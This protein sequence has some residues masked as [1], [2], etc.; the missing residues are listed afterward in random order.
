MDRNMTRNVVY[1]GAIGLLALMV[2]MLGIFLTAFTPKLPLMYKIA[3]GYKGW[4]VVRYQDPSCAP[5]RREN[6]FFVISIPSSGIG[7]TSDV[8][9]PGWRIE[10]YEYV[11]GAKAIRRLPQSPWGGNGEIWAGFAMPDKHSESFFVGSEQ[12]LQRSWASRPK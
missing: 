6:I 3:D 1:R 12:E 10:F 5:F 7:C 2:V 11:S 9:K 8:L 4:A